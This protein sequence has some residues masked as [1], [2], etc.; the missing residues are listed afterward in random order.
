MIIA[1]EMTDGEYKLLYILP[2]STGTENVLLLGMEAESLKRRLSDIGVRVLVGEMEGGR[3]TNVT[4][5]GSGKGAAPG[6][7]GREGCLPA[8]GITDVDLAIVGSLP[9]G[10]RERSEL[11]SNIADMLQVPGYVVLAFANR[12]AYSRILMRKRCGEHGRPEKGRASLGGTDLSLRSALDLLRGAGLH[13]SEVY[14]PIPDLSNPSLFI[15]LANPKPLEFL[16][17]LF[18]SFTIR[19][20][21]LARGISRMLI[22]S[23]I[24]RYFLNQYVIV[25][26]KGDG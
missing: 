26:E 16:M 25:A 10:R 9:G 15:S 14:A 8:S 24:Y 3:I 19:K 21:V 4:G 18:G 13:E 7:A 17:A 23:G 6:G 11:L 5:Y 12:F 22:R 2:I 1:C 20:S